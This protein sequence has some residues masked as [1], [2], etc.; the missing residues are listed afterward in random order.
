M[1]GGSVLRGVVSGLVVGW[2]TSM[3]LIRLFGIGPESFNI[4]RSPVAMMDDHGSSATSASCLLANPEKSLAPVLPP[5]GAS[6]LLLVLVYSAPSEVDLRDAVRKTWL[7]DLNLHTHTGS[8]ETETEAAVRFVVAARDL[9]E[10]GL[11]ALAC[12]NQQHG[13][14]VLLRGV[15]ST[16]PL[17]SSW[18]LLE[19]YLWALDNVRFS[20]VLKCAST[21]FARLDK[22]LGALAGKQQS[23]IWGFFAGAV[24][25]NRG[26]DGEPE[27]NLCDK[28]L[29]YPC[30]RGHVLSR[31]LL[32]LLQVMS[33]HLQHYRHDDIALGAWLAPFDQVERRHNVS[34]NTEEYSRGCSE[35]YLVTHGSDPESMHTLMQ[36]VRESGKLCQKEVQ[37]RLS[38]EYDWKADPNGC[39][40]RVK[41]IP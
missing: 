2:C 21:S 24:P 1:S 12:E 29:P 34:F 36:R 11:S 31:D 13:D 41:G 37:E 33:P 7:S 25:A 19:G 35:S 23:L 26:G 30:G 20:Y 38:Y 40:K 22:I 3:L 10:S 8:P 27:W 14:L 5:S 4:V 16:A 6:Y 17:T 9:D 18:E 28:Y 39:C 15:P 32:E